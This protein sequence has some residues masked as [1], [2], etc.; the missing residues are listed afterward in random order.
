MMTPAAMSPTWSGERSRFESA[1]VFRFQLITQ[2]QMAGASW[3]T[4][5]RQ[6]WIRSRTPSKTIAMVPAA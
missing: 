5:S 2:I 6:F 4:V 1:W 3:R